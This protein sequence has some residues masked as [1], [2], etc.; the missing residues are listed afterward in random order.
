MEFIGDTFDSLKYSAG[1][2]CWFMSE[3][4]SVVIHSSHS[5]FTFRLQAVGSA[6]ASL[7]LPVDTGSG[8]SEVGQTGE[9]IG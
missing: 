1:S 8:A 4:F 2:V 9:K 5:P 3:D 6:L 7:S